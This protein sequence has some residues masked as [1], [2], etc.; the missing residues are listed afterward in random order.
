MRYEVPSA[1]LHEDPKEQPTRT[2]SRSTF[3]EVVN[4]HTT[5]WKLVRRDRRSSRRRHA[6]RVRVTMALVAAHMKP[7][8]D[9]GRSRPKAGR[10]RS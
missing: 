5:A 3:N 10:N 6:F 8:L 4:R 9:G 7:C 1:P 2:W